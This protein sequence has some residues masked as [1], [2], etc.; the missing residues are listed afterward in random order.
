[1]ALKNFFLIIPRT[2]GKIQMQRSPEMILSVAQPSAMDGRFKAAPFC[3]FIAWLTIIVSL[4]H[5]IKHFK[6]R[7]VGLIDS[8]VDA[9]R[10]IPLRFYLIIPLAFIMI[11][12]Q[13]FAAFHWD[14][15]PLNVKGNVAAIYAGGYTP[16]LLILL[17]QILFGF[18][19][20]NEDRELIRQR[21]VRGA[22]R[23][24][25]LGIV[26]KP[27]WWRRA[28]HGAG[29]TSMRD[30]IRQ[31]VNEVGGRRRHSQESPQDSPPGEADGDVELRERSHQP[32]PSRL[33][34]TGVPPYR[35]RSEGRR[36]ERTMQDAARL[37]FPRSGTAQARE[38]MET[39]HAMEEPPPSYSEST[40]G[41]GASREVRGSDST[42]VTAADRP[43]Q[44]IRS[45][46][47][48]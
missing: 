2:W 40:G 4:A 23:D 14:Y 12:Y 29:P 37:L 39:Q 36:T 42:A 24:R 19:S 21:R 31:N 45:M 5:S 9:F 27:V 26:N 7:R 46:L 48:V 43:P 44:Q 32:A 34:P 25:D 38:E 18:A 35:G 6:S 13:A 33:P 20:P 28:R 17:V 1:M 16:I 41:M 30:I 47:D 11:A 3:L 15:S 10:I 8:V 22:E